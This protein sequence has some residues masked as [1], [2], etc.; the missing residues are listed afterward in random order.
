MDE[1]EECGG[2]IITNSVETYCNKCGLAFELIESDDRE[3]NNDGVI[4]SRTGPPVTYLNPFFTT[5]IS[6]GKNDN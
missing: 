3:V 6:R 2:N 1:C 4:S 5:E